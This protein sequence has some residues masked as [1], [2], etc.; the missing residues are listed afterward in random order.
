[1]TAAFK[2]FAGIQAQKDKKPKVSI[3]KK[4]QIV[5]ERIAKHG[6]RRKPGRKTGGRYYEQCEKYT[7][8]ASKKRKK[9]PSNK[10]GGTGSGGKLS[11]KVKEILRISPPRQCFQSSSRM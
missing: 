6:R 4:L 9:A 10:T 1:M 2:Q 3:R 8:S 7:T 5:K 11:G